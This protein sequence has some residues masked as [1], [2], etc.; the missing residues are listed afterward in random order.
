MALKYQDMRTQGFWTQAV[1][2]E[3]TETATHTI[4]ETVGHT[5]GQGG[6][7]AFDAFE[8]FAWHN[9]RTDEEGTC[10][11]RRGAKRALRMSIKNTGDD[12]K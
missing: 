8:N 5:W 9:Y 4:T 2:V 11:T 10:K 1:L 3:I 6:R 12:S 7:W